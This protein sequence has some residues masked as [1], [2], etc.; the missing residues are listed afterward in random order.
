MDLND[1]EFNELVKNVITNYTGRGD[2][3]VSAIGF[4][5]VGRYLGWKVL[6]LLYSEPTIRS[7]QNAIGIVFKDVLPE[8]TLLSKKSNALKIVDSIGNFWKVVQGR[9]KSISKEQKLFLD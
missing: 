3:L 2:L 9:D 5:V 4:L 6:S 1:Y 7:Y 8:R